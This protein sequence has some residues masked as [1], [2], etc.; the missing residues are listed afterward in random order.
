MKIAGATAVKRNENVQELNK[1]I[2][3][4]CPICVGDKPKTPTW[5]ISADRVVQDKVRRVVYYRNARIHVLGATVLYLPVFW[6]ADPQAERSSGFLAP[7]IGA[8][9]RRGA[10][11]EQPYL[12][13]ISPYSDLVISPQFNSKV[14]PF[15]N[16]ALR[17]RFYSGDV[18]VRFGFTHDQDFDGK[19][20]RL[21]RR[22]LAQLHPGPGGLPPGAQLARRVHGGARLRQADLRQVRGRQGLRGPRPPMSPTTGA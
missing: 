21:R 11:Y 9:D 7:N 2:Y 3:T 22:H 1:A 4:P 18:N 10:S 6:H 20:Q 12:W 13:V 5:S 16:G 8:S 19:G 15:L 14:N 17:K